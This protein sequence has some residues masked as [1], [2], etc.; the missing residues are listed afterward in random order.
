MK[1]NS[2]L[3]I[4]CLFAVCGLAVAAQASDPPRQ[5]QTAIVVSVEGHEPDPPFHVKKTDAPAPASESDATVSFRL[6]CTVYVGR[7][8][9]AIDYLPSVFE[10]GHAVEISLGKPF[11]Y[12]KV[13]G[14]GEVK[15]RIVR[16][17][18][19]TEDSCKAGQ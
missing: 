8:K 10:A 4:Y 19:A 9:S 5:F 17:Y 13:P 7:Y 6:N 1:M 18:A 16:H 12:A 3:P 15:L 14:N 11:L 2:A